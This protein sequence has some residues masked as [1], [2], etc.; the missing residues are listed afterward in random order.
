MAP[1]IRNDSHTAAPATS[2]AAPSSAKIPAPT[3]APTPMKAACRT[4]SYFCCAEATGLAVSSI[5]AMFSLPAHLVSGRYHHQ[6]GEHGRATRA[7]VVDGHRDRGQHGRG[8]DPVGGYAV[9]GDAPEAFGE[10]PILG[11]REGHLGADHG[12]PVE[13]AEAGDD[14]RDRHHV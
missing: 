7:E 9:L 11:R 10:K 5:R 2:P 6:G 3:I 1:A 13:R 14:D 12:P 4:V 8:D